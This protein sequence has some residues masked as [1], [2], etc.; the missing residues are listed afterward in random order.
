MITASVNNEQYNVRKCN[1]VQS[2]CITT[3]ANMCL[4][5]SNSKAGIVAHRRNK[6]AA[7]G[8]KSKSD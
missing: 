7:I 8:K 1:G 3:E 4:D 2:S 6:N 5:G